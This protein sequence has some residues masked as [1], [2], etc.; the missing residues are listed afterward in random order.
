[1][2]RYAIATDLNRCVGCLA[3]TVACKVV[4]NVPIGKFWNKVVRIGPLPKY[5]GAQFPDVEMSF[6]PLSCQHCENA[7]C[8]DVCPTG[9]SVKLEDGT[10]QID[11]DACIGCGLCVDACPYNVRYIDA[12]AGVA[13]KCTLCHEKL[14]RG[15]LPQCV[16]QCG[17]RA[18]YFG[19]LDEGIGSFEAPGKVDF[20]GDCSYEA[21]RDVRQKLGES[22]EAFEEGDLHAL[23]DYGNGP[24]FVYILRNR[25]WVDD[26]LKM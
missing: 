22:V 15:E 25:T 5:E 19:D 26:G 17:G 4:N 6:L 2:A 11:A 7:P 23:S 13:A 8:A 21:T 16:T 24:S 14:E 1:M 12:G 3:C 10:V 9:A 20:T 18:R